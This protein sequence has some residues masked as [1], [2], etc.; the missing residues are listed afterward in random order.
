MLHLLL[1]LRMLA[2]HLLIIPRGVVGFV[3]ACDSAVVAATYL[4]DACA[5]AEASLRQGTWSM[6]HGAWDM[7]LFDSQWNFRLTDSTTGTH[8]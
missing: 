4:I 2:L 6:G 8:V 5:A 3:A 1:L 7:E